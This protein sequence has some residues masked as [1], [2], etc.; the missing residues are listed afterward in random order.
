LIGTALL[1]GC[2]G[3]SEKPRTLAPV[4]ETPTA[5]PSATN[6]PTAEALTATVRR[7]YAALNEAART[8]DVRKA[9]AMT[10]PSCPCRA[11]TESITRYTANGGRLEGAHYIL[12][13]FYDVS[14]VGTQGNVLVRFDVPRVRAVTKNGE[15]VTTVPAI[16]GRTHSVV[17]I[18]TGGRWLIT[19]VVVLPA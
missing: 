17:A 18:W 12:H 11:V 4:A 14:L 10:S 6:A 2:S 3:G 8:G 9:D 7:Y 16:V 1:A 19:N 15:I 13:E 5:R